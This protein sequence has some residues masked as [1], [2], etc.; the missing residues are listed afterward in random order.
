MTYVYH[1]RQL[2]SLCGVHC[3]N[4]LLQG[5]RFG[6]G[7]FAEIGV[8]FDRREK[9]LLGSKTA[10]T[11]NCDAGA[12]GGNFS[13]QVLR[14]AIA[15]AGFRLIPAMHPDGQEM[16][17][18]D[19][20]RAVGAYL[21]QQRDHWFALRA[22]DTCWWD[23]D[24]LL[25]EPKPLEERELA[26]RVRRFLRNE[27]NLFLVCGG[28]LPAPLPP[29]GAVLKNGSNQG[30]CHQQSESNWYDATALLSRFDAAFAIG[31]GPVAVSSSVCASQRSSPQLELLPTQNANVVAEVRD[32]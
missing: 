21:V 19:P 20:A 1:E 22:T 2:A 9:R 5:P 31:R 32:S 24:S 25:L 27:T 23:L 18:Q 11:E 4:N 13:I 14:V 30:D 7:D 12:D 17:Q 16:L 3:V 28:T 8:K 6:P 29:P 26:Q 10:M 15:R